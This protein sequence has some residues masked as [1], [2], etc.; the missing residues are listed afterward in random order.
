MLNPDL[1]GTFVLL[2]DW[3]GRCIWMNDNSLKVDVGMP[4][5]KHLADESQERLKDSVGKA[6]TSRQFQ[7]VELVDRRGDR[8]RNWIWPLESPGVALCILGLR[9][10]RNIG[11]LTDRERGCLE[12]LARGSD[13]RTIAKELDVSVSTVHTHFRHAREKLGLPGIDALTVFAARYCHGVG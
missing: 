3:Q 9:I 1:Y 5:W 2:C 6:L 7:Q 11:R 8:F 12:I 10:P 4:V 13:V